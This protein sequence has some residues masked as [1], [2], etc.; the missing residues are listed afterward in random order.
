ML[1]DEITERLE[2]LGLFK[3]ELIEN[4]WEYHGLNP[5]DFI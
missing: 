3:P 1:L 2:K 5:K 4:A